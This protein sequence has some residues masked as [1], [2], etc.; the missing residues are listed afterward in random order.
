M[1][2]IFPRKL[3]V[4][5]KVT[6]AV[7]SLLYPVL[8]FVC[9]VVLKLPMRIFSLFIIFLA[10]VYFLAATGDSS[11]KNM[12]RLLASAALLFAA[13]ILCF[14]TG[15]DVFVRL[16][17]VFISVIFL[18]AFASTL[19][20]QPSMI[21][22]FAT[23]Q[24]RSII[25]CRLEE[26]IARY[27]YK[28]TLVWC[29]FFIFNGSF[30]LYTVLFASPLVWSVYNGGI[31]YVL[32]GL[33]FAGEFL[34]RRVVNKKMERKFE[35]TNHGIPVEKRIEMESADAQAEGALR[36]DGLDRASGAIEKSVLLEVFIPAS[37]D[38][39]DGHFEQFKLMPAVAQIDLVTS[40]A[41]FY[42]GVEKTLSDIKRA[43][44]VKPL[45]PDTTVIFSLSLKAQTLSFKIRDK[46]DAS[47]YATGSLTV[48][49][50]NGTVTTGD[51]VTTDTAV[52]TGGAPDRDKALTTGAPDGK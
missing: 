52:T 11:K 22:R 9:L 10:L 28:V 46:A 31:S 17:P 34:V 45:R 6:L 43:K 37:S 35:M 18:F 24:D 40:Y 8:V 29:A 2:G 47:V 19:L 39:F 50:G 4:F 27:C 3:P 36:A 32:M 5:L 48:A 42:F 12:M 51:A 41:R 38:Y 21:F 49:G 33:L 7:L 14:L 15:S 23:M 44:F 13:G 16:Y 30:A 26:G 1:K 25:G 20:I